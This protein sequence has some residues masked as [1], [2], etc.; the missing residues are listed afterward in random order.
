M[1]AE[2]SNPGDIS[3]RVL[4]EG[5]RWSREVLERIVCDDETERI[6]RAGIVSALLA[7]VRIGVAEAVA[8]AI[9]QGFNPQLNLGIPNM[10]FDD[11][12]NAGDDDGDGETGRA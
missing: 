3:E 6:V 9:E 1:G 5:L 11:L 10:S 4:D 8:Q 12:L 2:A 7:G